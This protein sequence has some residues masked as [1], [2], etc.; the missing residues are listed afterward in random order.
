MNK[1]TVSKIQRRFKYSIVIDMF[2]MLIFC[3]VSGVL[4]ITYLSGDI[5]F[6]IPLQFGICSFYYLLG[7]FIFRNQSIG[8]KLV[9]I[10]IKVMGSKAYP[11][12]K[13][14]IKRRYL[15]FLTRFSYL[16]RRKNPNID[17]KTG[18]YL[19]LK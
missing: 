6:L 5:I 10:E 8:M 3:S 13:T 9:R 11:S 14:L 7:D 1:N 17:E 4:A 18:T 15:I 12:L 16:Y 2:L 19:S